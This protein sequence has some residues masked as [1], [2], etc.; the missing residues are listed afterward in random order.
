MVAM[1]VI[2]DNTVLTN[3]AYA[4]QNILLSDVFGGIV[5]VT[6]SVLLELSVGEIRAGVPKDNWNWLKILKLESDEEVTLYNK[7]SQHL[8][9]G[10][11]SC[12]SL[13]FYRNNGILT[14]D[15]DA[16]KYA[17]RLGI[18]VS[19]TIGI[20]V[21]SIRK[22]IISTKKGNIILKSMID[23]GYYSPYNTLDEIIHVS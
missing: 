7:I 4:N 15:L 11:S 3:F 10:E 1:N 17:Q 18:P 20:L 13:A 8:G 6:E 12:L 5:F 2:A 9:K 21:L 23:H 19:G 22:G 16:R 14:D